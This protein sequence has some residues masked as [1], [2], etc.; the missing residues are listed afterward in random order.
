[1]CDQISNLYVVICNNTQGEW[2]LHHKGQCYPTIP[3]LPY[4]TLH[5][6][7]LP[8]ITLQYLHY[9]TLPY[10]TFITL[11][12]STIPSL[13]YITLHYPTLPYNT[14]LSSTLSAVGS[15]PAKRIGSLQDKSRWFSLLVEQAPHH[16]TQ[17]HPWIAVGRPRKI[18]KQPLVL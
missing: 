4:I 1:L 8:Y 12:Y 2:C 14:L 10:N 18:A 17:P 9:L 6:P 5:Y 13:P 7:T 3:S 16:G 15:Y 11:H